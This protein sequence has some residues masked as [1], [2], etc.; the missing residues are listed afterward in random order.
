LL[1]FFCNV[2]AIH[3][4]KIASERKTVALVCSTT[5]TNSNGFQVTPR[6]VRDYDSALKVMQMMTLTYARV[7]AH[8]SEDT[9][10]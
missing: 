4:F 3:Y 10:E 7:A 2:I 6:M 9:K 5:R 1:T 8:E